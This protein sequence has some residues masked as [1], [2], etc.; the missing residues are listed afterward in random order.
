LQPNP[1]LN[2][3]G[4]SNNDRAVIIHTDD[5]GMC[6]ASIQAFSDLY[7]FGLI[8]SGSVMVPCPWFLRTAEFAREHPDA[9][10]GVHLTLTCEW[11]SY[12]W[13]PVSTRDPKSGMI[14]EEGCFYH[15]TAPAVDHGDT[16]FVQVE[17]EAQVARAVRAGM[18]PTHI[19]THMGVSVSPK[20]MGGYLKVALE[21]RLP[22]MIF[23]FSEDILRHMGYDAVSAV[24][25]AKLMQ[26]LE[27]W[28]MP[29]LDQISFMPLDQSHDQIAFAK[30]ALDALQPGVT[31]FI[32]HPSVD[33]PELR[34]IAP[35]WQSRVANYETFMSE[36]IRRHIHQSGIQV[37]GYRHLQQ[38]MPDPSPVLEMLG[39]FNLS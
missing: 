39:S 12:R 34:A 35:D 25:A 37:I 17:T 29:L 13:G 38:L 26:Q 9:D 4:L 28:G 11:N 6:Q 7:D 20:F 27:D 18:Q 31:H 30:A 24:A 36:E 14:D 32:L 33:T 2:R 21:N 22:A 1:I 16:I 5:I 8:S 10:L 15:Q 19:D 23:R 3:L